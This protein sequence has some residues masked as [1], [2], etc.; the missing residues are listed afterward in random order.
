MDGTLPWKPRV[1]GLLLC[2]GKAKQTFQTMGSTFTLSLD[3]NESKETLPAKTKQ[4]PRKSLSSLRNEKRMNLASINKSINQSFKYIS[5][6]TYIHTA[7]HMRINARQKLC[8]FCILGV[9]RVLSWKLCNLSP[10]NYIY[11]FYSLVFFSVDF[12]LKKWFRPNK[13]S[14]C[15]YESSQEGHTRRHLKTHTGEKWNKCN[16]CYYASS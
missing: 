12:F 11:I 5:G 13:F 15:D 4:E 8:N 2:V 10:I 7:Y 14:Q 16:Q 9:F 6:I 3:I 1:H